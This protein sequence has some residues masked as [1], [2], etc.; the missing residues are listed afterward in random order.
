[1]DSVEGVKSSRALEDTES[2]AGAM[3]MFWKRQSTAK[4]DICM[5]AGRSVTYAGVS[6][7]GQALDF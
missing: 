3:R 5:S 2:E 7:Y 4:P 1:M 6:T